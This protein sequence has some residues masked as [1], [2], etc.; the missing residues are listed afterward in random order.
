LAVAEIEGEL[1]QR[2]PDM[3]A[4]DRAALARL[5]GG[6]IGAALQLASGDGLML[7]SEA[8]RLI[9]RAREPDRGAGLSLAGKGARVTDGIGTFGNFLSQALADRIVKKAQGG[10]THLD[11]WV[12]LRERL[13]ASYGRTTALYLDLRQTIVSSGRALSQTARRS[14]AI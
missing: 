3:S 8:D 5:S 13:E 14:G 1:A 12:A 11:R 10:G 7:A 9:D 2:L 6:S 4:E